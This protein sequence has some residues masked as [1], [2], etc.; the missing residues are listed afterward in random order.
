MT[1]QHAH[2]QS[3]GSRSALTVARRTVG[4]CLHEGWLR[5]ASVL[6]PL[7]GWAQE[8]GHQRRVSTPASSAGLFCQY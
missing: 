4:P 3:K 8:G 7:R 5:I 1:P 2:P 6:Q